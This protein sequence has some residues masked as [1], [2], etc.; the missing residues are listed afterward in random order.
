MPVYL[1]SDAKFI[2]NKNTY[3]KENHTLRKPLNVR[4]LDRNL[5]NILNSEC[6]VTVKD[7]IVKPIKIQRCES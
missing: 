1:K 6:Q 2:K 5:T 3:G 7:Q 4:R